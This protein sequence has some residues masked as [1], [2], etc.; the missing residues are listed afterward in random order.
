MPKEYLINIVSNLDSLKR[1][2][3]K[4]VTRRGYI[5]RLMNYVWENREV[6]VASFTGFRVHD[7]L[8]SYMAPVLSRV[9]IVKSVVMP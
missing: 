9:L 6:Y 1:I 8:L 7:R 3:F 4:D 5:F 2:A